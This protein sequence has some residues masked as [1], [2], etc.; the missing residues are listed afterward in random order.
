[1]N[2]YDGVN[3][4]PWISYEDTEAQPWLNQRG[5][6]KFFEFVVPIDGMSPQS[7]HVYWQKHHSPHV[8]NITDFSQFMK[9]YNTGHRVISDYEELPKRVV[10]KHPFVGAAEVWLSSLDDVA[11]WL[12][13]SVYAELIQPDEPRFIAQDGSAEIMVGKEERVLMPDAELP[14]QNLLKVYLLIER[15]REDQSFAFNSDLSTAAHDL[16]KDLPD[17]ESLLKLI[18]THKLPGELPEGL[19]DSPI[20][21]V[22]ELW[23]RNSSVARD[24]VGSQRFS[25]FIGA[26]PSP[27]S[28]RGFAALM[29]VVHDEFSFQPSVTQPLRFNWE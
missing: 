13:K 19:G 14:E 8:M 26:V 1:M 6:V 28:L 24:F 9:K 21:A 18:I 27:A 16:I 5:I 23:F 10:Q 7:F 17:D 29:H 15:E 3:P 25:K 22:V 4:G 11:V 12:G 2:H 20:D